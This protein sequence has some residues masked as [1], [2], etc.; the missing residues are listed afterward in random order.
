MFLILLVAGSTLIASFL[1]SLFEAVLYS[2]TP[3]Q[4]EVLKKS[5][6]KGA[7]K[8]AELRDDVEEPIAAILTVNTIAHTI[9]SAVCGALVAEKYGENHPNAVAIFAAIFTFLVLGLTEI[10]PKSMGVRYAKSM[11]PLVAAPIQ[12]MVWISY[13]IARPSKAIMRM[14]TG[15]KGH[16]GPSEE[17][18]VQLS[19]LAKTAGGVRAEENRWVR[20]ALSLDKSTAADLRTPRPVVT[21]LD[22][23][24]TIKDVTEK[25]EAWVH[26]RV[27]VADGGDADKIVGVVY[28]KDVFSGALHGK[29]ATKL[30]EIMKPLMF[31][32]ETMPAHELL[33]EFI[34]GRKHMLAVADEYGG[35]EGVVT[36][37]DVVEELLGEEIV[38]EFDEHEDMQ[39]I[40]R[41]MVKK[42]GRDTQT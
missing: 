25:K 28:R 8:L 10:I 39:E 33:A 36:L 37:E 38:D 30:R 12:W 1:C 3:S 18:L 11:G 32:P 7:I 24:A 27:P 9:G 29:A 34:S 15:G 6:S 26:S 22:A 23:D 5:G 13:P 41:E 4:V 14:L 35:F 21:V 40:A 19:E 16:G 31:V 20:N 42:S 2:V 17:E